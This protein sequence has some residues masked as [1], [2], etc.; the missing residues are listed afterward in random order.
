MLIILTICNVLTGACANE[1]LPYPHAAPNPAMCT[2]QSQ[3]VVAEYMQSFPG[4]RAERVR[5]MSEDDYAKA[6]SH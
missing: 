1:P 5:C 4:Y 2:M 6:G 3:A